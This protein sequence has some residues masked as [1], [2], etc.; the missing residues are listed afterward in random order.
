MFSATTTATVFSGFLTEVSSVLTTN[1]PIVL[2]VV[3]AL[4][5]LGI[6]IR[7]VKRHIGRKA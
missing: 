3:G 1:L 4:I 7:F 2:G 5:G 6:V